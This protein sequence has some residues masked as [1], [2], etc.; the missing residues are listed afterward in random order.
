MTCI[1][2]DDD[3]LIHQ[4]LKSYISR[5]TG[6]VLMGAY[7]SPVELL[8][9]PDIDLNKIDV[10]FLDVEMPEMTGMEF[11]ESFDKLPAIVIISA[12]EEYALPAFEFDVV[13]YIL[14]PIEYPRFLKSVKKIEK[15]LEAITPSDANDGFF[16]RV[17]TGRYNKI[18]FD[19]ILW[20]EA[21]ENYVNIVTVKTKHMLHFTMKALTRQLPKNKF[22]RIHRSYI[23]NLKYVVSLED[24][25]LIL[26]YK[27]TKK[28]FPVAKTYKD[29]LMKR[30]NLFK[31]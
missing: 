24:N 30:I 10:I 20:I 13:D 7:E 27:K 28:P 29:T 1:I 11:L 26:E 4:I 19:D 12:K 5:T 14:K 3:K 8:N 22:V 15:Y 17:G 31:S 21:F 6:C 9:D 2:I 16:Y 23:V 18:F 25:Y